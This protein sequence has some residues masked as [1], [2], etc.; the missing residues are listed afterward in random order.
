MK[1]KDILTQFHPCL[2]ASKGEHGRIHLPVCPSCNL[3]C[4]YCS[5]ALSPEL[6]RPGRSRGIL[7]VERVP[8]A[9]AR[10]LELCPQ[11]TTVGIAGPGDTLATPH[12]LQAFRLVD[13]KFPD[14]IKCM[15]TNGL[16]LHEMI[17]E[18]AAVHVDSVTV[19]VNAA[20]PEV[21]AKINDGIWYEGRRIG[22]SQAA[23]ILIENQRKG[24]RAASD[25]G[26]LVKVN[27]VLIPGINEDQVEEI[28]RTA[29]EA[30]AS[31]HNVIPLIPQAKMQDIQ[32]PDC[33]QIER[34][35]KDAGR[36]LDVFRH[37]RHCRADAVGLLEGQDLGSQVFGDLSLS[38]EPF[39]H[40]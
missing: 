23:E 37:C 21:Q 18:I 32:A 30:G 27:T 25:R 33:S 15:S 16:L 14:L 28:A 1:T 2:S 24:I 36:Y 34:A 20:D 12:A 13:Q 5:R 8:E 9:L 6:E 4:R 35:R 39:S 40:G 11:L 29:A 31:I 10:G 22:G 7:P 17:D 19:T 38:A 26:I 3:Q